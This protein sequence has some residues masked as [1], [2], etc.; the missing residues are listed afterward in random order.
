M[1]HAQS[2]TEVISDAVEKKK[3]KKKKKKKSTTD[4][5]AAD[6]YV[7]TRNAEYDS[8]QPLHIHVF[9]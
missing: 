4:C 3:K 1:F 6:Q 5:C 8:S 2:T 7:P 9:C